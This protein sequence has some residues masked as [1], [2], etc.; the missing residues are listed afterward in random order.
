M[1]EARVDMMMEKISTL[2]L[3]TL[4]KGAKNSQNLK[5]PQNHTLAI[6]ISVC[7][8]SMQAYRRAY[9]C[10]SYVCGV[11]I[12]LIVYTTMYSVHSTIPIWQ[13]I[14]RRTAGQYKILTHHRI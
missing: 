12:V 9:G 4:I 13:R 3:S 6:S 11:R 5:D 10:L 8:Y 14:E 7:Q 1:W 2:L